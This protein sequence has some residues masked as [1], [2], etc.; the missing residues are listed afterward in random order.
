MTRIALR[1]L[2]VLLLLPLAPLP[3]R[4]QEP[5]DLEMITRI[6]EEGFRHSQVMATVEHLTDQIGPRVTGSPEAKEALEWTRKQL[7]DWGLANAHLEPFEFGRGWSLRSVSA[8]VVKPQQFPLMALPRAY[9]PGTSRP[10][11]GPLLVAPMETEKDLDPY[12]GKVAGKILLIDK[13]HDFDADKAAAPRRYTAETLDELEQYK[14]PKETDQERTKRFEERIK[15]R[16]ARNKFLTEEKVLA[17][18]ESSN[19]PWGVLQV[20]SG[21]SYKPGE[22]A[23]SPDLVVAAEQ[24]NRLLRLAEKNPD[25]QVEID[26]K[27]RYQDDDHNSYNTIAEIPGTDPNGEVVMLGAHLDSWHGSTGATD[28]AAG[29]AVAMETVRILKALGVKPRRTIRIA[30]W[31]GEEQGLFGSYAYV[32]QHFGARPEP[33]DPDLKALSPYIRPK[34]S[35]PIEVKPEHAKLSAYFNMDNGGGKIRGLY[36]EENAAVAPIFEAWLRPLH[37]LGA[38]TVTLRHTGSTDHVAFDEIGLPGFQF[39][40]DELDYYAETHHTNMDAYDHLDR[41]DLMQA[42]VVMATVVYHAAMRT[43]RMPRKP[44]PD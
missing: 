8:A 4:A 16:R 15:T 31:T 26:V 9:T 13:T 17:I 2:A 5:V 41:E 36:A 38:D 43:D 3:V 42:S 39:I 24:Y 35:G 22:P 29:C 40:Q 28:N 14:V 30:L 7:A 33:K 12:R 21:G 20:S 37:D 10:V 1:L 19:L 25:V 18:L 32:A 44:L 27:S 34:T 6:R 23:G 11:R